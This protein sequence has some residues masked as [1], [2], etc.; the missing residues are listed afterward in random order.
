[1]MTHPGGVSYYGG[2]LAGITPHYSAAG[3]EGCNFTFE[4]N[5]K[6]NVS[7]DGFGNFLK[8]LNFCFNCHRSFRNERKSN[9]L[10]CFLC[11]FMVHI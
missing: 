2:R 9:S 1:M 3:L 7:S 5:D 4:G 11:H 10:L 6:K 8:F